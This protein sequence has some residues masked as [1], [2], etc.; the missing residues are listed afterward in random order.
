MPKR[1]WF[2]VFLVKSGAVILVKSDYEN[3]RPRSIPPGS[4]FCVFHV[5]CEWMVI[6]YVVYA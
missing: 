6:V 2:T 4:F 5:T 1:L 3:L